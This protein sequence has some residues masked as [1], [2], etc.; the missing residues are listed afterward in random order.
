MG[1][2]AG[3]CGK[4]MAYSKHAKVNL[5]IELSNSLTLPPHKRKE[6]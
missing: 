6:A 2:I 5:F 1:I 4:R 3:G